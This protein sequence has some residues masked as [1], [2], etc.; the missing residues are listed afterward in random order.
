MV[1]SI[2]H[3]IFWGRLLEHG[4]A[5]T[6]A[7]TCELPIRY[8]F[9]RSTFTGS[10]SPPSARTWCRKSR[11]NSSANLLWFIISSGSV[12]EINRSNGGELNADR[13]ILHLHPRLPRRSR[14]TKAGN[15][16]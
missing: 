12:A 10:T 14:W 11:S 6:R 4:A 9:D 8:V 13:Q 7:S 1:H 2:G 3:F 15:P 5:A 16:R